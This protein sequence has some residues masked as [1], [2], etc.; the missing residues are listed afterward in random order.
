[1][2]LR[3]VQV[4]GPGEGTRV[5]ALDEEGPGRVVRG[6]VSIFALAREAIEQGV[7][8]ERL[9]AQKGLGEALD[10]EEELARGRVLTP[11]RSPDDAHTVVSGTGLTHLG[12]AQ[13][14][15]EMHRK[16]AGADLTDSMKMFKIGLEGGK[17][18]PGEA[19]AQPE[20]FYKG[21]GSILAA[22]EQPLLAP[23]FGDDASE[24][25]EIVGIYMAAPDGQPVR[26]GFALGNELSDHV[27]EQQNYLYLAHSKLRPC[28]VGPELRVGALPEA[29]RGVS[30]IRRGG[31]VIWE[32]EFLSGE[33]HMAHAIA[34]LEHHH[35]KHRQ[36]R[37]PGDVHIHFFGAAVLSFSQGVRTAPGDV[38]EI[39]A[40]AF[41]LPLRNPL[42]Q[43]APAAPAAVRSL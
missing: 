12:S 24:E 3:L 8:L 15:D 37:R 1:M 14:R 5:A 7:G 22:P 25:A 13:S 36:F 32:S 31:E 33:T 40:D 39:A 16:L 41:G 35:F 34:N 43:A 27:M 20:W 4:T 29:V 9:V 11:V 26:L 19:G 28:S 42:A 30:R 21:D 18:A 23:D 10:L 6:A 2:G 17:P 38:F